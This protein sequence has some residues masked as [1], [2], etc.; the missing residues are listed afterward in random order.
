MLVPFFYSLK[1]MKLRNKDA[2]TIDWIDEFSS[3]ITQTKLRQLFDY[4][5]ETGEFINK[6]SGKSVGSMDKSTG[7]IRYRFAGKNYRLHRLIWVWLHS[8]VPDGFVVDHRNNI[9]TD[10]RADNL[11]LLSVRGNNENIEKGN[12][13]NKIGIRGVHQCGQSY[14]AVIVVCGRNIHLGMFATPEQAGAEYHKHKK[15]LH[16]GYANR[17]V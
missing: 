1:V 2:F 8:D 13:N 7:Y 11:R 6:K 3:D 12:R 16:K 5:P 15:L 4:N 14:R 17:G 10:N 9:R